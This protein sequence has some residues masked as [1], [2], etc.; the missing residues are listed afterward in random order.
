MRR[1]GGPHAGSNCRDSSK[2][3]NPIFLSVT[4]TRQVVAPVDTVN[5]PLETRCHRREQKIRN[6]CWRCN[7]LGTQAG[8]G[9]VGFKWELGEIKGLFL[10]AL[11]GRGGD[12]I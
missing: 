7:T 11:I 3:Q 2:L 1:Q 8:D 4:S 12:G 10:L 6:R 9:V 5:R